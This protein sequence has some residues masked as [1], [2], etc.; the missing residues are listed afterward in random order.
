MVYCTT[1]IFIEITERTENGVCRGLHSQ[2]MYHR[3]NYDYTWPIQ[4]KYNRHNYYTSRTLIINNYQDIMQPSSLQGD[5]T[6]NIY[7]YH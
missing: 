4:N 7:M 5:I 2:C 3:Y 1:R 6:V